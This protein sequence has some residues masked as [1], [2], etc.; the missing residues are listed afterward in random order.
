VSYFEGTSGKSNLIHHR[1]VFDSRE[2]R[3]IIVERLLYRR[4]SWGKLTLRPMTSVH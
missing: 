4:N 1:I 3:S 2:P